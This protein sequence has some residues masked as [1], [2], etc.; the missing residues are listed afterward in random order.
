MT[1]ALIITATILWAFAMTVQLL[2]MA[3]GWMSIR[4]MKRSQSLL[5]LRA[6]I[7]SS[8]GTRAPLLT[9]LLPAHNEQAGILN[10]VE[11]LL[12]SRYPNVEVLV[13]D[14]GS[15]DETLQIL[16]E[17]YELSPLPP[18]IELSGLDLPDQVRLPHAR[19]WAIWRNPNDPRLTVI[20]KE[21]AGTKADALNAGIN[22]AAGRILYA[23]DADG[24]P[25]PD[26]LLLTAATLITSDQNV[27]AAGGSVLPIN[28][29]TV[30][31]GAV[32]RTRVPKNMVERIQLLEYLRSFLMS[33]PALSDM[34][35][36]PLISGAFGVFWTDMIRQVGGF[37][38]GS[39][40]EDIDLTVRLATTQFHQVHTANVAQVPSAV[41]WTEVPESMTVLRRQRERWAKGLTQV[42]FGQR[43]V[44]F[45]R[46]YGHVGTVGLPWMG[47]SEWIAPIAEF[48][49]S[50]VILAIVIAG[51]LPPIW[52]LAV[53]AAMVLLASM[54]SF[55]AIWAEEHFFY[56]FGGKREGWRLAAAVL[57]EQFGYH[58]RA[59][60]WK[61]KGGFGR[62][63]TWG[64]M[65]RQ[66][67]ASP[68]G[69]EDNNSSE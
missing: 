59:S 19:V 42:L 20:Q 60:W 10:A 62:R 68:S 14:D 49:G 3:L 22:L 43:R 52:L 50:A 7:V 51:I 2:T 38:S 29:C 23:G 53:V 39:F 44:L 56:Y 32:T 18:P 26:A 12:A 15:T 61:L 40:G 47:I 48:L 41:V 67:L 55:V 21:S 65:P 69:R 11:A 17:A 64:A 33:R 37:T 5:T 1:D 35:A 28:S 63:T 36:L 25:E 13:V 8:A 31:A 54:N 58:Q 45:R 9:A 66:G 46:K 24:I 27:I 34:A 57:A 30:I 6:A 4:S 16:V